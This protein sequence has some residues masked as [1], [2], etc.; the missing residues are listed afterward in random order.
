MVINCPLYK[1]ANYE[2][3]ISIDDEVYT[4]EFLWVDRVGYWSMSLKDSEDQF[5]FRNIFL[6]P[7]QYIL[8]Q[9]NFSKP[10]GDFIL[11]PF[12]ISDITKPDINMRD[13]AD[14]HF[15]FYDSEV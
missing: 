11:V 4:A 8:S 15:L 1:D 6:I 5:I 3:T 12:E 2:Y 13:M 7:G 10:K 9:Y 14:N